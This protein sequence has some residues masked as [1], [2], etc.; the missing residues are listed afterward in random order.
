MPLACLRERRRARPFDPLRGFCFDPCPLGG[1]ARIGA[2]EPA[3]R[4]SQPATV[5]SELC[6]G[7]PVLSV[8][9]CDLGAGFPEP[10]RGAFEAR[11]G[12]PGLVAGISVAPSPKPGACRRVIALPSCRSSALTAARS[13][14][15]TNV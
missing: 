6:S 4:G 15:H 5:L 12:L 9:R 13:S 14:L 2:A 1:F 8:V 10:R 3:P 11:G 7:P